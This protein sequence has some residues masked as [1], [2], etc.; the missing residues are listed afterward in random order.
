MNVL[1]KLLLVFGILISIVVTISFRS[2]PKGQTLKAYNIL[3]IDNS[4]KKNQN[5]VESVLLDNEIDDYVCLNN[6]RVPIMLKKN[7]VEEAMFKINIAKGYTEDN[8]YLYDRQNYFYDS[9]GKY[10]LFYISQNYSNKLNDVL[11]ELSIKE[12]FSDKNLCLYYTRFFE[13]CVNKM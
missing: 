7:S 9:T 2:I 3:Y 6:Q 5:V 10:Q 11:K 12:L 4:D 1:K 13:K 8:K